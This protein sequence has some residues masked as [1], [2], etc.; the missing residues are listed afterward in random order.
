MKYDFSIELTGIDGTPVRDPATGNTMSLRLI[1]CNEL[2]N[3]GAPERTRKAFAAAFALA[4][5]VWDGAD[6]T[7]DELFALIDAALATG[8]VLAY[9][10]VLQVITPPPT[11]R[12][13]DQDHDDQAQDNTEGRV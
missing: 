4:C 8:S 6:I 12:L 13:V 10:R 1:L 5:K 2:L 3:R 7:G 11:L 9:G